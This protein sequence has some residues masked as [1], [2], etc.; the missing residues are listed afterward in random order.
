M[1]PINYSGKKKRVHAHFLRQ[2]SHILSY[3]TTP[4]HLFPVRLKIK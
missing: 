2:I 3:S 4:N 1:A